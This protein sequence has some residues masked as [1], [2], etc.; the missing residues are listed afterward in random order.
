MRL[1]IVIFACLTLSCAN[2]D[3]TLPGEL[4]DIARIAGKAGGVFKKIGN[5]QRDLTPD[6]EYYLGRALSTKLL[7][8][9]D[10]KYHDRGSIAKG[11]LTG[12]TRYVN[13]VGAIVV[14]AAMDRAAA[15]DRPNP[16][17]GYHFIVVKSPTVAAV[18]A[19]GGF[20]FVTDGAVKLAE[21]EDELAALLAHEVAHIVRG[22]AL[23][24]IKKSRWTDAGAELVTATAGELGG[25]RVAELTRIME[26][27]I[28][29]M[30]QT[31]VNNGY[32]KA[33][34]FEADEVAM[35]L[36]EGA[37][38]DPTALARYIDRLDQTQDA[39]QGGFLDTHP[40]A[41]ARVSK[42]GGLESGNVPKSR[43]Q[44]FAKSKK[45]HL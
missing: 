19:P 21:S 10:Y 41:S 11:R 16:V 13:H 38:Y 40:K 31:L 23:G 7:A 2:L 22:H 35:G 17:A 3:V 27:S 18:S 20:V 26:N 39:G 32:S 43:V 29:D 4:G 36:L 34:E 15:D 24:A 25:A 9:Y 1:A 6:N 45:R 30:A 5:A 28:D 44:R 33:Y 14:G 8:N 42:L 37:G 12:I